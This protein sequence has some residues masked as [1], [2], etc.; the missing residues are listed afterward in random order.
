MKSNHS[1]INSSFGEIFFENAN[2]IY[3]D[4]KQTKNVKATIANGNKNGI[5]RNDKYGIDIRLLKVVINSI[6]LFIPNANRGDIT[7]DMPREIPHTKRF[8]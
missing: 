4:N 8:S 1:S 5:P 3:V 2:G 6:I 7:S